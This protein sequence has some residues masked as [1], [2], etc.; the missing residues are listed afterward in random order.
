[1]T[2]HTDTRYNI[3]GSENLV[4]NNNKR[5][6][7]DI[8]NGRYYATE[9]PFINPACV[10]THFDL[11]NG[12]RVSGMGF[13]DSGSGI[14]IMSEA[15]LTEI[16]NTGPIRGSRV[17]PLVT[18]IL[19]LTSHPIT[20]RQCYR[21]EVY[22]NDTFHVPVDFHIMPNS[23]VDILFGRDFFVQTAAILNFSDKTLTMYQALSHS[24]CRQQRTRR[25]YSVPTQT[26]AATVHLILPNSNNESCVAPL[27][28]NQ[29]SNDYYGFCKFSP[30]NNQHFHDE[31]RQQMI[32]DT[33]KFFAQPIAKANTD[34]VNVVTTEAEPTVDWSNLE[35]GH[36][37]S[38][39]KKTLMDML[40]T[41]AT[42]YFYH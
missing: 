30:A 34:R 17:K 25:Y 41:H 2:N 32:S 10:R 33:T 28:I 39:Q 20:I 27:A 42:I 23:S 4:L 26:L 21:F 14:S 13:I 29:R 38:D 12:Q 3:T 18:R 40:K 5:P 11:D 37:T 7:P 15:K 8:K 36:L 35:T 19:T 31:Q 6:L 24:V 9:I 22:F 1:M 16:L